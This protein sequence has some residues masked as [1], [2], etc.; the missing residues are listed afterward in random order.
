MKLLGTMGLAACTLLAHG[1]A[2]AFDRSVFDNLDY[3]IYWYSNNTA[4]IK[5][6]GG[7]NPNFNPSKPTVIYVHGWQKDTVAKLY[8][9]DFKHQG[10]SGN[11]TDETIAW[12]N[13]GYNVGIFYWNQFSDEGEVRDAQAKVWDANGGQYKMRWRKSDG[14]YPTSP[15]ITESAS[16]LFYNEYV[17]AMTGYTGNNIRIAGHSLGNRMAIAVTEKLSDAAVA[18]KIPAGLVPKRVALLDPA[19]LKADASGWAASGPAN[20]HAPP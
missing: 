5:A 7:T 14:S 1:Q 16:Q 18:G 3:G 4:S 12:K 17:K 20:W 2:L 6:T 9:E 13:A 15:V 8:R 11:P 19:Y 10:L